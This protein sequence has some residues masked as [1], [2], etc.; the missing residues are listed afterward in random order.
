MSIFNAITNLFNAAVGRN[1]DFEQLIAAKDITRVISLMDSHQQDAEEAMKEYDP[2]TH[3]IMERKDKVL[4]D[5]KGNRKGTLTRWKL[6]IGYPVYINEISLVFLF[7][8]P[9]KWKQKSEGADEGFQ[10]YTDLLKKMHFNT[11]IRQCKRL[12][13]SETESAMLFRVYRNKNNEPDCQIR[14]LAR[15]KGDE[16]YTR[17]DVF[18]NLITF[19]W[20]HYSK[21][22]AGKTTY[23]LDIFTD[24][25]I[26]HCQRGT[27]GWEV[28]EEDNPIEKIPV[29][30]FM[31]KKEWEGVEELINREE[32]VAS[33]RADTND[34]FS[35]PYLL[36]KQ[37]L[38]KSM[39]NKEVENKTLL[40]SDNVDDVNKV[41][42]FLTWDGQNES[43]KDELEWLRHH[44]LTKTF[45]PDIDWSQFKGMSQM[46][47]KAL[48]Q[49]ML[50]ADIKASKHKENYDELLDRTASL[51]ISIMANVLY[52]AKSEYKLEELACDHDYQEPFGEDI[53][54]TIKNI[55]ESIDGG[56]MSEESGI[57][58]NPLIKDKE[59]EKQR[60]AK[61]KEENV[62]MQQDLFSGSQNEE[63]VFGGAK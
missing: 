27:F 57:E 17:W 21:D 26:Y 22:V 25:T 10:A 36:M 40:V 48:K 14:V 51:V 16:I 53:A 56:T 30:Y 59:L 38:L 2:K 9:V 24:E 42:G 49:M 63:D 43:K 6:P 61:Q 44:I 13:G 7:G 60:L 47:G 35:D 23:H 58:Q 46:S 3:L 54:E 18:E 5:L 55:N 32:Y 41:A 19:A 15:S 52:I 20:G 50:L 12:A 37:A 33:R 34:Y 11:K 1:Q 28:E 8:Q 31:Q 4:K 62:K 45:T 39:P 29:I